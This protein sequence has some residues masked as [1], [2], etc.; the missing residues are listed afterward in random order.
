MNKCDGCTVCCDV[1]SVPELEKPVNSPCQNCTDSGC[2]IHKSRPNVCRDFQCAY[3]MGDW[4]IELRPDNCGVI[5]CDYKGNLEALKV[6]DKIYEDD[7]IMQQIRFIQKTYG[8]PIE[9][10]DSKNIT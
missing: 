8:V 9:L 2:G 5:I 7:L 3:I 6:R 4:K 10:K 1:F